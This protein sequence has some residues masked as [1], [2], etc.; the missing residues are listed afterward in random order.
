MR[1]LQSF[2]FNSVIS[3]P[4]KAAE[5]SAALK[6]FARYRDALSEACRLFA[7]KGQNVPAFR[8]GQTSRF[9][10]LEAAAQIQILSG[11][12]SHNQLLAASLTE[13][14]K[15]LRP[16]THS[17]AWAAL[18]ILGL[19]PPNDAF[20]TILDT[21]IVEIY[22]TNF[23]QVFRSLN[24]FNFVSYS[25]DD[26]MT[27]HFSELY[28]RTGTTTEEMLALCEAVQRDSQ[29]TTYLRPFS[30][31]LLKETFGPRGICVDSDTVVGASLFD[32][33]GKFAGFLSA[34]EIYNS[35]IDPH[36]PALQ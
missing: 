31:C 7:V 27:N 11:L 4:D 34:I 13:E 30:R 32:H 3:T 24:F 14:S 28:T 5:H 17:L 18:K 26:L 29:P 22:N 33:S 8:E 36:P 35:W 23:T 15:S 10:Q 19:R 2:P 16:P 6:R 12:E 9:P 1:T 20:S 21:H 25:L